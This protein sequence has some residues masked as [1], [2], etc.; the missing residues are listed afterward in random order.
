MKNKEKLSEFVVQ[1][2]TICAQDGIK[3]KPGRPV[4]LN[5]ELAEKFHSLGYIK[6]SMD[7]MFDEAEDDDTPAKVEGTDGAD[8]VEELPQPATNTRRSKS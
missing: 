4:M 7:S 2:T 8:T 6:I 1:K 5:K 3:Y